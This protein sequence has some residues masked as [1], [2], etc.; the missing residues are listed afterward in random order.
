MEM[1]KSLIIA[2]SLAIGLLGSEVHADD[3]GSGTMG[4]TGQTGGSERQDT[5]QQQ[6]EHR[7]S[8][9]RHE[10]KQGDTGSRQYGDSPTGGNQSGSPS[11]SPNG[12]GGTGSGA[13]DATESGNNSGPGSR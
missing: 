10:R 1:N 12:P 13:T 9:M 5:M 11:G 3:R 2:A 6:K 7:G 8:T 4:D